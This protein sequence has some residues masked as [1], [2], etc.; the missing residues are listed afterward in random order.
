MMTSARAN[1][2][3][4]EENYPSHDHNIVF[5]HRRKIKLQ[6]TTSSWK[7]TSFKA[8]ILNL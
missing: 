4:E 2:I 5:L 3:G 7:A 1:K 8:M 6:Q